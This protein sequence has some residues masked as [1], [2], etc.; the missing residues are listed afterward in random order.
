MIPNSNLS[1]VNENINIPSHEGGYIPGFLSKVW[2]AFVG[3]VRA[4][5][6]RM[7]HGK[8]VTETVGNC[9]IYEPS[10]RLWSTASDWSERNRSVTSAGDAISLNVLPVPHVSHPYCI[11]P[12]R[13]ESALPSNSVGQF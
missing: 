11:S 5:V 2:N 12:R 13:N 4:T 7:A 8:P 10:K 1:N 3:T 6:Q 9:F